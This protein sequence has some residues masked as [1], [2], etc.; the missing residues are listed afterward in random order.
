MSDQ[1][2]GQMFLLSHEPYARI[3]V[4]FGGNSDFREPMEIDA[5]EFI[6]VKGVKARGKRLTNYE[7]AEVEELEPRIVEEAALP[8]TPQEDN[9]ETE[10]QEQPAAPLTPSDLENKTAVTDIVNDNKTDDEIR[11]EITGQ[12]RLF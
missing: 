12:R 5:E 7:V 4:T 11:D 2:D 10:Q 6:A 9:E 1:G 3:K 8:D